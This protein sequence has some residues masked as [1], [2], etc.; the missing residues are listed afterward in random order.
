MKIT[1]ER[2]DD[3]Y[4][5]EARA[6][7]GSITHTD[8]S[9]DI[10]G[11]NLAMRPMQMMLSALGGCSSIDIIFLLNKQRQ[12]LRDIKIELEAERAEKA[13]R[14]FTAIRVHYKL[15]G[16]LDDKKAERAC[17]LSM[18]KMCSVSM[19]LK[20]SVDITWSYEILA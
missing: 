9:P 8:G 17:R 6:E 2:L 1:L 18:E 20:D 16:D 4:H 11:H 14:V 5:M 3:A 15:F 12:P 13:P 19:M 10:G 7:D